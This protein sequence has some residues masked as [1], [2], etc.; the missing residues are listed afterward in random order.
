MECVEI[1]GGSKAPK[2]WQ[3][4]FCNE[5]PFHENWGETANLHGYSQRTSLK[6]GTASFSQRCTYFV[7]RW[8][9]VC[10]MYAATPVWFLTCCLA[11]PVQVS[12]QVGHDP[13]TCLVGTNNFCLSARNLRFNKQYLWLLVSAEHSQ[14]CPKDNGNMFQPLQHLSVS[15][16]RTSLPGKKVIFIYPSQ[17]C[18][19]FSAYILYIYIRGLSEV[20][21]S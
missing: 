1:A 16:P 19:L 5:A 6:A 15:Y 11:A 17:Q 2:T 4:V 20:F 21:G 12:R 10:H 7:E 18:F 9:H 13:S 14:E 3:E 8:L